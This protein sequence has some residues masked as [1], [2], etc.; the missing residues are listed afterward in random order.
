VNAGKDVSRA[1]AD[2][3]SLSG[4]GPLYVEEVAQPAAL[5]ARLSDPDDPIG[6]YLRSR[7][8]IDGQALVKAYDGSDPPPA[9]MLEVVVEELNQL[10]QAEH[11]LWNDEVFKAVAVRDEVR[12]R[13]Q[14]PARPADRLWKNRFRLELALPEL[15][16]RPIHAMEIAGTELFATGDRAAYEATI[17]ARMRRLET[18]TALDGDARLRLWSPVLQGAHYAAVLEM[19]KA[20]VR[21]R[22]NRGGLIVALLLVPAMLLLAWQLGGRPGVSWRDLPQIFRYVYTLFVMLPAIG[23]IVALGGWL[24]TSLMLRRVHGPV[25]SA[26]AFVL[27]PGLVITYSVFQIR[28]LLRAGT[29]ADGVS[30]AGLMTADGLWLVLLAWMGLREAGRRS[31]ERWFEDDHADIVV[32]DGLL[33]SLALLE[34]RRDDYWSLDRRQ[35]VATQL[36][37]IAA[38]IERVFPRR[39]EGRPSADPWV[40]QTAREMAFGIRK[41]KRWVAA[42][43][44]DTGTRLVARLRENLLHAASGAWG[45]LERSPEEPAPRPSSVTTRPPRELIAQGV[46]MIVV[47][48]MPLLGVWAASAYGLGEPLRTQLM[49]SAGAWALLTILLYIDPNSTRE[50]TTLWKALPGGKGKD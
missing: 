25:F 12:K 10:L 39:F 9:Q 30:A 29:V 16:P 45:L 50:L 11:D 22:L 3:A 36:E 32:T 18:L 14:R 8:T 44:D 33:T 40:G 2:A 42:P 34:G 28:G 1:A 17:A 49:V 41:L 20:G 6:S 21:W 19:Q 31:L 46:R 37:R 5:V 13:L 43:L 4:S 23:V 35:D 24:S 48:I 38:C 15:V 47:A 7:F 26:I 27:W